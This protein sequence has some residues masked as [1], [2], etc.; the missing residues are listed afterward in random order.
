MVHRSGAAL[1]LGLDQEVFAALEEQVKPYVEDAAV[2][3]RRR[4]EAAAELLREYEAEHGVITE[5]ELSQLDSEW[6]T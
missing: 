3:E 2:R 6:L 4:K 1:R 5:D